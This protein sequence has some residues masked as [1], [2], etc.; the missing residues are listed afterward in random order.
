MSASRPLS[1]RINLENQVRAQFQCPTKWVSFSA[2]MCQICAIAHCLAMDAFVNKLCQAYFQSHPDILESGPAA[3]YEG[4]SHILENRDI[5]VGVANLRYTF[6]HGRIEYRLASGPNR[7]SGKVLVKYFDSLQQVVGAA[8]GFASFAREV[9]FFRRLLPALQRHKRIGCV[10]KLCASQVS[11]TGTAN[12]KVLLFECPA[13]VINFAC[14]SFLGETHLAL[15]VN[16]IAELHVAYWLAHSA[17]PT[18]WPAEKFVHW[19]FAQPQ[20]VVPL[21][22]RC[23]QPIDEIA[24]NSI[25]HVEAK[26]RLRNLLD[27]FEERLRAPFSLEVRNACWT[28]CHQSFGQNNVVFEHYR[29]L[30]NQLRI[31]NWQSMGY[32]SLGVDLVI[33]LFVEQKR[34]RA[35]VSV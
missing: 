6:V 25:A 9:T 12:Q 32:A 17:D 3:R 2:P 22:K 7:V 4:F 10:P 30:P 11:A 33:V 24:Q 16:Q 27:D 35:Q 20:R 31:F 21:L 14:C 8:D 26:E 23:F 29:H 1:S 13:G 19:P 15:M 34:R 5:P 28:M 18:F